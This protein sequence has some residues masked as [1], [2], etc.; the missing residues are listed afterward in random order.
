[1]RP[2]LRKEIQSLLEKLL[3]NQQADFNLDL[4][5]T[6]DDRNHYITVKKYHAP[7]AMSHHMHRIDPDRYQNM[8]PIDQEIFH[9][10]GPMGAGL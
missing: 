9:I 2:V 4:L 3:N 5:N 6:D 8:M 7:N 10:K 1:M